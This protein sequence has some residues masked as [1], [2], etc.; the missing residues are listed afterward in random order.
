MTEV[1]TKPY[2]IRAIHEWCVD[3]GYTPYL[4][5]AVNEQTQVP[6]EFVKA[7]EIVLNTSPLAT[8]KLSLG[9]EYVEFEARFGGV[10][11]Q[12]FVPIE[13]VSAIYARENGHGMAFE[14]LKPLAEI[15]GDGNEAVQF[16]LDEHD[17]PVSNESDQKLAGLRS[18]SGVSEDSQ[19]L[20]VTKSEKSEEKT[21]KKP[22]PKKKSHLTR[23]K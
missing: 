6:K 20:A 2:L 11:R 1:S 14:V 12:I 9:N 8:N 18:V 16:V 23:V 21:P 5:V 22:S 15:E 17:E 4:A 10:A 19:L 13:Q 7:G 3:N